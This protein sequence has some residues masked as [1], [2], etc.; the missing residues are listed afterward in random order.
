MLRRMPDLCQGKEMERTARDVLERVE[1]LVYNG[2]CVAVDSV[3]G[4]TTAGG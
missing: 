4:K 3:A 1:L 2:I